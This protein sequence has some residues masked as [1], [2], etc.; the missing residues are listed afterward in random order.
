MKRLIICV[1]LFIGVLAAGITGRYAVGTTCR[2]LLYE[3]DCGKEEMLCGNP[4]AAQQS[5]SRA[6]ALFGKKENL[7]KIYMSRRSLDSIGLT[8]SE[9]IPLAAEDSPEF[10]SRLSAAR[11]AVVRLNDSDALR[12]INLL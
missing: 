1:I 10:Y 3:L 8:L 12:W 7:L 2:E 9:L 11:Q 6:Q 5:L 4:S